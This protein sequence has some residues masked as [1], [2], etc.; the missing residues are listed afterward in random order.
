MD[1]TN[2]VPLRFYF[3]TNSN[4]NNIR[5]KKLLVFGSIMKKYNKFSILKYE[6]QNEIIRDIEIS[7]YNTVIDKS[8]EYD[9]CISWNNERFENLYHS[10][11]YN[12]CMNLDYETD[13]GSKYL[14]ESILN[15][16]ISS[17]EV[18]KLSSKLM[19]PQKYIA[20]DK[21]IGEISN[22][23]S[24]VKTTEL[25]R[26]YKCKKNQCTLE[27]VQTRSLDEG[28][29]VKVTCQYCGNSWTH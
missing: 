22:I 15:K 23:E 14:A 13:V 27:S 29:S 11:C 2:F 18:G 10:I 20:I 24:K 7:C 8:C 1:P 3:Y 28:M 4:Y 12:V 6:K 16:K 17:K 5:R 26:C 19:C 9:I 25:Y 21:K